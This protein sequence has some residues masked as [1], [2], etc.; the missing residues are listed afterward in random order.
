MSLLD[1]KHPIDLKW[2]D[3]SFILLFNLN[4]NIGGFSI[5]FGTLELF[6]IILVFFDHILFCFFGL[7]VG[8]I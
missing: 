3:L 8:S 7:F 5:L 2:G 4:G 1:D 6:S